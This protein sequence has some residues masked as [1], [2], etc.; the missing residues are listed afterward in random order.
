M[1]IFA[2][3]NLTAFYFISFNSD[4]RLMVWG[5]F[6][7]F[8]EI[9]KLRLS[10]VVLSSHIACNWSSQAL[11]RGGFVPEVSLWSI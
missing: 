9:W 8:F 10:S 7:S 11:K 2:P 3:N 5:P 6:T 1:N 4:A